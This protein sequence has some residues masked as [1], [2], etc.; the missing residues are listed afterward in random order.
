MLTGWNSERKLTIALFL[1]T[2]PA[3]NGPRAV[4]PEQVV[5]TLKNVAMTCKVMYAREKLRPKREH[6]PLYSI[7]DDRTESRKPASKP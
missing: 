7:E 1:E 3:T 6:M 5:T 4:H 2:A